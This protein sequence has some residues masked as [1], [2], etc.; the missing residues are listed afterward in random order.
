MNLIRNSGIKTDDGY[1]IS[2]IYPYLTIVLI[3][4]SEP[5]TDSTDLNTIDLEYVFKLSY[6]PND[7]TPEDPFLKKNNEKLFVAKVEKGVLKSFT[8]HNK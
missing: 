3:I 6:K 2:K 4:P 1:E 7:K 5:T 8:H